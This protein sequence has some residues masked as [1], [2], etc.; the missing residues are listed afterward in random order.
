MSGS[1]SKSGSSLGS[2]T[3][4]KSKSVF[5]CGF[6]SSFTLRARTLSVSG[7]IYVYI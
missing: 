3:G 1:G 6:R 4:C 2:V 5:M 7:S